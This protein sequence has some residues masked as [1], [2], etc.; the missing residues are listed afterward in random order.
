M[1]REQEMCF[2]LR[3]GK[4]ERRWMAR[5]AG[6]LGSLHTAG[7]AGREALHGQEGWASRAP[8]LPAAGA[9][10]GALHHSVEGLKLPG[11][12]TTEPAAGFLDVSISICLR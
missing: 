5:R 11:T 6:L 1:S 2:T 8:R 7:G 12:F 4:G 9:S 10:E 3:K